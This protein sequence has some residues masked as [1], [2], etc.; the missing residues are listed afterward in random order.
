MSPNDTSG[1]PKDLF[2]FSEDPAIRVFAPRPVR[3]G[4]DRGPAGAWLNGPLVWAIDAAQGL[5]YLFP[6]DCPRI[7]IWP[8]ERTSRE[9]R[10]RWFGDVTGRAVAYVE[11]DWAERISTAA[12]ER[13]RM[14]PGTFEPTG[15]PGTWVSK[16]PVV[17]TGHDT[18]RD[19]PG[20]MAAAG[21]ELRTLP[22]LTPL[23]P[24]WRSTL[25]ASGIR[26]RNAQDWV[27][28]EGGPPKPIAGAR[29][30]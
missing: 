25:H 6:R 8:T 24:I 14:P 9:D 2:H 4:V 15:E 28:P 13:Y 1:E 7:V 23:A 27:T 10:R 5:L 12:I 16:S 20:A 3:V 19:L 26:L 18:I 22:R 11:E 30:R 29:V 21:L 17:P